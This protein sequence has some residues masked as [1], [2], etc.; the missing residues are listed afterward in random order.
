MPVRMSVSVVARPHPRKAVAALVGT[1]PATTRRTLFQTHPLTYITVPLSSPAPRSGPM[2]MKIEDI[3]VES[4][5]LASMRAVNF[6][7][8]K[9]TLSTMLDGMGKIL[10]QLNSV[11]D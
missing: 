4:N 10:E 3:A 8:T 9:D 6:E 2:Q 7:V 11:A 1:V 5:T